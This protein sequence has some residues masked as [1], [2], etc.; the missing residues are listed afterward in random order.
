MSMS[1]CFTRIT[2][3]IL[4][5]A[6][7]VTLTFNNHHNDAIAWL[8]VVDFFVHFFHAIQ[9]Y[10]TYKAAICKDAVV[11]M[12]SRWR[13][14][15]RPGI[16]LP[17]GSFR[18]K[19]SSPHSRENMRAYICWVLYSCSYHVQVFI[20]V[21]VISRVSSN[22]IICSR[23]RHK[24]QFKQTNTCYNKKINSFTE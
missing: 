23:L 10:L 1:A 21:W 12:K 24:T 2:I 7:T 8:L 15:D 6:I 16:I 3:W 5:N 9:L 18:G 19:L 20:Q 13:H 17:N 4:N 11:N 22:I 14:V